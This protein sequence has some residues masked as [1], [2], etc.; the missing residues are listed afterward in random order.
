[1]QR[2]VE[3]LG[4]QQRDHPCWTHH[5]E[6][7]WIWPRSWLEALENEMVKSSRRTTGSKQHYFVITFPETRYRAC[8]W[9]TGIV[10]SDGQ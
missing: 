5:V 2:G 10:S 7:G 8:D 6:Q 4:R 9:I 1:M 3:L